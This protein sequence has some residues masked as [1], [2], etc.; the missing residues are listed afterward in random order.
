MAAGK[1]FFIEIAG[2]AAQNQGNGKVGAS[3]SRLPCNV[4][5]LQMSML[6]LCAQKQRKGSRLLFCV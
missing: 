4:T 6:Q 1:S 5:V 2:I 3:R